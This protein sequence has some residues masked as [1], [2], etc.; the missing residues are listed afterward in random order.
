MKKQITQVITKLLKWIKF[1]L[2]D[3]PTSKPP[4]EKPFILKA[5]EVA[6]EYMVVTY[7][8]QRISMLKISYPA[9]KLSS[10]K[11]KRI[12]RDRFEK[13]EKQG[14]IKFVE[15][16]GNVICVRN[17]DYDKRAEKSKHGN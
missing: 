3:K 1:W 8:G 16:E 14:L 15:V 17:L 11:D 13:Q 9:W 5:T 4:K 2:W 7:H 6:K 12:T 10:R